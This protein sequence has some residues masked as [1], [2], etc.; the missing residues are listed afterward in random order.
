[1][2]TTLRRVIITATLALVVVLAIYVNNNSVT[3]DDETSLSKP[4]Y[5]ERLIPDSGS[6]VPVQSQV[7]LDLATGY[8]AYLDIN[9][10][11]IRNT[12]TNPTAD[13]LQKTL[14]VGRIVYVPMPG[15][16]IEKLQS[17]LNCV[18]ALIWRQEDGQAS[19]KPLRWCFKGV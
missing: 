12:V 1:V 7:G 3:G 11:E 18:T 6:D 5:V 4:S 8:D 19:A 15:H 13:G 14:T 9:G 17:G 10:V 16:R 2:N